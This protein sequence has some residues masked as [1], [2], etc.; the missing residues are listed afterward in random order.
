ML[1][2]LLL[3]LGLR[4]RPAGPAP[5]LSRIAVDVFAK[6]DAESIMPDVFWRRLIWLILPVVD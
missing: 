2:L 5:P 6:D 1:P 4:R 3:L